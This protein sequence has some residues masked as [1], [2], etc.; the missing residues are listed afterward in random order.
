LLVKDERVEGVTR[1]RELSSARRAMMARTAV[2]LRDE[3]HV[4]SFQ[5]RAEMRRAKSSRWSGGARLG[6]ATPMA[7]ESDRNDRRARPAVPAGAP[8]KHA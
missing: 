1:A 6:E 3:R 8:R 7:V 5:V 4:A 2:P